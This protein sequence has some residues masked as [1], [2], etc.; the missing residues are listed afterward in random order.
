MAVLLFPIL[1]FRIITY[2]SY[3]MDQ[4]LLDYIERNLQF[5]LRKLKLI[6]FLFKFYSELNL[7]T[8]DFRYRSVAQFSKKKKINSLSPDRC[9]L[10]SVKKEK[11]NTA[12]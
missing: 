11:N 5:L 4:L 10:G 6:I 9:R 8:P 1:V 12:T 7:I 3:S 2:E